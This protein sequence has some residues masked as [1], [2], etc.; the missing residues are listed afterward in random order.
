MSHTTFFLTLAQAAVLLATLWYMARRVGRMEKSGVKAALILLLLGS[1]IG[2]GRGALTPGF[3]WALWVLMAQVPRAPSR[4]WQWVETAVLCPRRPRL[5]P[6]RSGLTL[7]ISPKIPPE[8]SLS[9]RAGCH[10][11]TIF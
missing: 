6:A 4:R 8:N 1:V 3:L 10:T 5:C 11:F 7:C 9:R 2:L